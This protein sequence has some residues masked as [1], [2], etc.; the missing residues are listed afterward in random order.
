MAVDVDLQSGQENLIC[1]ICLSEEE[2]PDHELITPCK[3]MGSMRYI[4][5]SCLKEWLA[6]KRH[7]K[8]TPIVNSYIWK[9]LECE[10]CKN[11]FK[12]I[13]VC[14]DG[15]ELN[16]LNYVIHEDVKNY[17][18]IESV[19]QTTSKTI[20][21]INFDAQSTIKV[22]RAQLAEVRITD[23]SVSRHHSNLILTADGTV[24]VTDNYSKF[25]TLKLLR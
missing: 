10:I 19:T 7:C 18:I 24:A 15:R 20:H 11:P 2:L 4:G 13:F 9:S 21:V 16:L 17:M 1:R 3:C 23:I 14:Q 6:G 22:G 25:G 8:E 5:L 12:D